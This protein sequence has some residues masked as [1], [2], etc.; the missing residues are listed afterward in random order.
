M[1]ELTERQ[2]E[3]LLLMSEYYSNGCSLTEAAAHFGVSKPSAYKFVK[4]LEEIGYLRRNPV[5]RAI[6]I[7]EAGKAHVGKKPGL[8]R[9]VSHWLRAS[10]AMSSSEAVNQARAMVASLEPRII[11]ALLSNWKKLIILEGAKPDLTG[12][13]LA[14]GAYSI[15]FAMNKVN[16]N[17]LSHGDRGLEKPATLLK[18]NEVC[19]IILR[20]TEIKRNMKSFPRTK[21]YLEKM[22]YFS[23]EKWHECHI[24]N[25]E[26]FRLPYSSLTAFKRDGKWAGVIRIRV[27]VRLNRGL[28]KMP[29]SEADL[30]FDL[31]HIAG[32]Q[33]KSGAKKRK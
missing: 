33:K 28:L 23:H 3:Y 13:T 16:S 25:G 6:I 29:E 12:K 8:V 14:N 10:T 31:S 7:T 2:E 1:Y 17:T 26:L 24:E 30:T 18:N 20:P 5:D 9:Q 22:W 32:M 11:R 21:G 19:D 4:R 15:D 27:R